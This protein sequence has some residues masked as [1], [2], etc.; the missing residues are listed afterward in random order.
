MK[1]NILCFV[2]YGLFA[3]FFN[4]CLESATP[5]LDCTVVKAIDMYPDSSYFSQIQ[6]MQFYN[7]KVYLLDS[8]RRDIA[9]L[10]STLQTIE[11][12][13]RIGDGPEDFQMPLKFYM[14][15]DTLYLLDGGSGSIKLFNNNQ[16]ITQY[17][18]PSGLDERFAKKQNELYI[19]SVTDSSSILSV[20]I[21]NSNS[22]FEYWG[23]LTAFESGKQTR[24][25]NNRE[26]LQEGNFLYAVSDNKFIVEKYDLNNKKVF[27]C[28]D[29]SEVELIKRNINFINSHSIENSYYVSIEDAY[30]ERENLYL[31]YST[32]VDSY[33]TNT[34]L[35]IS[36]MPSMKM[37][38]LYTLPN[39]CY[40]SICVSPDNFLY[41]F[42]TDCIIEKIKLDHF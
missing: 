38:G 16:Y 5:K 2:I 12:I 11:M 20:R 32:F 34:L 17:K 29:F 37:V 3:V 13:G 39:K 33:K 36:L 8:K 25:R 42:S 23:E 7:G 18:L 30:I 9:I 27:E 22:S 4:S 41:A 35:K 40:R 26:L 19:P 15:K 14:D 31:L 6:C 28:Y 10:D 21:Q 1:K 24:L